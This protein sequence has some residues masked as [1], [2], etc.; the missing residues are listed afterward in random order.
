[1]IFVP[2]DSMPDVVGVGN[3]TFPFNGVINVPAELVG[4]IWVP[5]T[6]L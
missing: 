5:E 6:L 1:M 4:D 2:G 3:A